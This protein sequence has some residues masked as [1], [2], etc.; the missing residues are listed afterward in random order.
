MLRQIGV[1][2]RVIVADIDESI[3]EGEAVREYVC[4]VAREKAL[5]V[6]RRD[7]VTAAI[8]DPV[9]ARRPPSGRPRLAPPRGVHGNRYINTY[10]RRSNRMGNI[11]NYCMT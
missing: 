2:Y 8:L 7:G 4:R 6:H 3:R 10:F 9:L 11:N 5:E 1:E